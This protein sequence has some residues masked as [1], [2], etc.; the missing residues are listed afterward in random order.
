VPRSFTST[1]FKIARA[2]ATGRAIRTGKVGRRAK[3]VAVGRGIAKAGGW[4]WLW[5]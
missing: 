2:S 1:A 4:K 3:N 5:K